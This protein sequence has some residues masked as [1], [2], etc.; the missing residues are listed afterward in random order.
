VKIIDEM[1][2]LDL[3]S[4]QQ[5]HEIAHWVQTARTPEA[6]LA[7]PPHL[8]RAIEAASLIMNLDADLSR[9]PW[10]GADLA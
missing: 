6:I 10:L 4:A 2:H 3:L 9:P 5:H 8:W 7:M 1:L